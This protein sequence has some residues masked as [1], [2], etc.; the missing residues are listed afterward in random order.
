MTTLPMNIFM[1]NKY[2]YIGGG[3][4]LFLL[5][6]AGKNFPA[7]NGEGQLALVS[8][9]NPCSFP[10]FRIPP[11]SVI[12][13]KQCQK[14]FAYKKKQCDNQEER[15]KMAQKE[16]EEYRKNYPKDGSATPTQRTE[17]NRLGR[18]ARQQ[19]ELL[20]TCIKDLEKDIRL[21]IRRL[22]GT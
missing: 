9:D 10:M 5:I 1:T 14:E 11:A 12:V 13:N 7:S 18:I 19:K 3:L 2:F 17:L 16:Y 21:C 22:L 15:V 6:L 8:G 4:L 20:T